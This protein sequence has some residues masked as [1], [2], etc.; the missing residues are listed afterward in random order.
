MPVTNSL[1]VKVLKGP[2]RTV[3]LQLE[4]YRD[5]LVGLAQLVTLVTKDI[6]LRATM[7]LGQNKHMAEAR[8]YARDLF[9]GELFD[10]AVEGVLAQV[11]VDKLIPELTRQLKDEYVEAVQNGTFPDLNP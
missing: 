9:S 2:R 5:P 11:L 7:V 8:M 10:V 3:E 4:L 1:G 6:V